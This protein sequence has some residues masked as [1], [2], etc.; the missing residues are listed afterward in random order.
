MAHPTRLKVVN[1]RFLSGEVVNLLFNDFEGSNEGI[2][3]R[4]AEMRGSLVKCGK[5][6][7]EG[8][9]MW[10]SCDALHERWCY[11]NCGINVG[12]YLVHARLDWIMSQDCRNAFP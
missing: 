1:N 9:W 10:N 3:G 12:R 11:G 8:G 2:V 7:L 6:P 5:R 4:E